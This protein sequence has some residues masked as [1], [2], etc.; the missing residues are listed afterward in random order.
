VWTACGECVKLLID[1]LNLRQIHKLTTLQ[2]KSQH[3]RYASVRRLVLHCWSLIV[4]GPT[5][6]FL[7]QVINV[8]LLDIKDSNY[9]HT[10]CL[11]HFALHWFW[12]NVP[13]ANDRDLWT[14][15][16]AVDGVFNFGLHGLRSVRYFVLTETNL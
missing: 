2:C 13:G 15:L 4:C 9:S 14:E 11:F 1:A 3:W 5:S 12:D 7:L 6:R 8:L 10:L 16:Y